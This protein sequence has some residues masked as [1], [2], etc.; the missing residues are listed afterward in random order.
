MI[1]ML[2]IWEPQETTVFPQS[3]A[4]VTTRFPWFNPE[5]KNQNNLS[6]SLGETGV[7]GVPVSKSGRRS[8]FRHSNV[9]GGLKNSSSLSEMSK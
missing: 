3:W 7:L 5:T 1:R 2:Q 9:K 6:L 4:A 8:V